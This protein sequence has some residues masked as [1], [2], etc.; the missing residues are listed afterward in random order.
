[1]GKVAIVRIVNDVLRPDYYGCGAL[2][3]CIE[4]G[5]FHIAFHKGDVFVM[6]VDKYSDFW[7]DCIVGDFSKAFNCEFHAS[8]DA[9]ALTFLKNFA[10]KHCSKDDVGLADA[11]DRCSRFRGETPYTDELELIKIIDGNTAL[12]DFLL[13]ESEL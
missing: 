13:K 10:K 5:L 12:K 3:Y 8:T 6:S 2:D 4:H 9:V 11:I 1:M 7:N